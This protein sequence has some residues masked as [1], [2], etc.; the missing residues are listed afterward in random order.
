MELQAI[1][2]TAIVTGFQFA[3]SMG[4][5][6]P[7]AS[8]CIQQQKS[9]LWTLIRTWIISFFCFA[10]ILGITACYVGLS[11]ENWINLVYNTFFIAFGILIW[12]RL[13]SRKPALAQLLHNR[14][15]VAGVA[16]IQSL[17]MLQ[18]VAA[19]FA[20]TANPSFGYI[21]GFISL[22]IFVAVF[23]VCSVTLL[24]YLISSTSTTGKLPRYLAG[25]FAFLCILISIL[26][27]ISSY[28]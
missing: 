16:A 5:F 22:F 1:L 15:F 3:F 21:I 7:L 23:V 26:N 2:A 9:A 18:G 8:V 14:S 6:L 20:I 17:I 24:L 11:W 4:G 28:G 10:L 27:L 12:I 19:V 25:L 13:F